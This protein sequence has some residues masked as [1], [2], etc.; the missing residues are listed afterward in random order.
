M[1]KRVRFRSVSAADRVDLEILRRMSPAAKLEVMR[2]L[3]QQAW[4]LKAAGLRLQHPDW[5][6]E[7]I[8]ARVRELMAGAGT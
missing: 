6:E 1:P 8:Q 4:E 3:W 7:R 5:S 2:I